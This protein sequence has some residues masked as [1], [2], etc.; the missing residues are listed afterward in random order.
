MASLTLQDTVSHVM[1]KSQTVNGAVTV[2]QNV[3]NVD[4]TLPRSIFSVSRASRNVH[5][6]QLKTIHRDG[7]LV[8]LM[9]VTF[10]R[11]SIQRSVSHASKVFYSS[12]ISAAK[13]HAQKA[14]ER[15]LEE[16]SVK[17]KVRILLFISHY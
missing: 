5:W 3:L 17:S 16:L 7:V 14:T 9:V 11:K 13:V 4:K 15:T 6:E 2:V 12:Q 10:V 8:V 1:A